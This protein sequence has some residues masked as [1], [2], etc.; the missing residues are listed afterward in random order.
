MKHILELAEIL[1]DVLL[2][3]IHFF[4]SIDLWNT[5]FFVFRPFAVR[6]ILIAVIRAAVC[7]FPGDFQSHLIFRQ[8]DTGTASDGVLIICCKAN[9][10]PILKFHI[11]LQYIGHKACKKIPQIA[12]LGIG[13]QYLHL[14]FAEHIQTV[15][16]AVHAILIPPEA[17]PDPVEDGQ[18]V[19]LHHIG[20][21]LIET[22]FEHHTAGVDT[23]SVFLAAASSYHLSEQLAFFK[24]IFFFAQ[25]RHHD[26]GAVLFGNF[27]GIWPHI[28][29]FCV[30]LSFAAG[31]RIV[32]QADSG[33]HVAHFKYQC[34]VVL[35]FTGIILIHGDVPFFF[36]I[37]DELL[38]VPLA[39]RQKYKSGKNTCV[40]TLVLDLCLG[41]FCDLLLAFLNHSGSVFIFRIKLRPAL[42]VGNGFFFLTV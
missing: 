26:V 35:L 24:Q 18:L 23:G 3:G 20:K 32:V 19:I 9:G 40:V 33:K 5:G 28:V 31:D 22:R 21:A 36:H 8:T 29:V 27:Y 4:L 37:P 17:E 2:D 7:R 39:F 6:V 42:C 12:R 1:L 30:C 41:S 15:G 25:H 34:I 38:L 13:T 10:L 11:I 14:V 16:V